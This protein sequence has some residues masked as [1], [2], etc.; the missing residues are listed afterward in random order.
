M[1]EIFRMDNNNE[2]NYN[3]AELLHSGYQGT[4]SQIDFDNMIIGK[5]VKPK[6][7]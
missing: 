1:K 4:T 2:I 7:V 5:L 3:K 6:L